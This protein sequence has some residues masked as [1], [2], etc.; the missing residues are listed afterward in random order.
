MKK[1]I[2]SSVVSVALLTG[3]VSPSFAYQQ[4]SVLLLN[5][6]VPGFDG[7]TYSILQ[8][9]EELREVKV[10]SENS[11]SV[12]QYNKKTGEVKINE[13][14]DDIKEISLEINL[15]EEKKQINNSLIKSSL[16]YEEIDSRSES[17]WG[18]EY[19][20]W[21]YDDKDRSTIWKLDTGEQHKTVRQTSSNKGDLNDFRTALKALISKQKEI[22][23]TSTSG[24]AAAVAAVV[25]A[26]AS[27]GSSAVIAL[28]MAVG[29]S[30]TV[31]YLY[32]QAYDL[33]DD[34]VYR[35]KQVD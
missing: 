14:S 33:Y 32:W 15:E 5:Q 31:A 22:N 19:I 18:A 27:L 17:W 6:K 9:T 8:D 28:V 21:K 25:A 34:V 24:S 26:P 11:E 4:E 16:S 7:F 20:I 3:L 23:A 29:V 10:T 35:Y 1:I 2:T 13:R 12:V 30:A